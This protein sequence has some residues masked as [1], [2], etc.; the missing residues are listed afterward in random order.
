MKKVTDTRWSR[1]SKK[2]YWYSLECLPPLRMSRNAFLVGE[3]YRYDDKYGAMYAACVE[4]KGKFYSKI[5]PV[6]TWNPVQYTEEIINQFGIVTEE[7]I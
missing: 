3:C 1:I 5:V 7:G 6:K 4:I 2:Y